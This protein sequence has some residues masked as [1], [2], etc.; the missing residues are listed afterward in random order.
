MTT[1]TDGT[2]VFKV[3]DK[4]MSA[5]F[6]MV[7]PIGIIVPSATAECP[8]TFGTWEEVARDRV[9]Q[10]GDNVGSTVEAGLPNITGEFV[11][12]T[13]K[14]VDLLVGGQNITNGKAIS[15]TSVLKWNDGGEHIGIPRTTDNPAYI[16]SV[17]FNA[18]RSNVI[19][20]NSTTVQ[21]PAYIVKFWQRVG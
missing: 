15:S 3:V 10:G 17:Q 8:F 5:V 6:D 13:L 18:S 1:I 4:R 19:Y 12:R 7:Y 20:G 21:P 16:Q 14:D 9:L 11:V 2:A